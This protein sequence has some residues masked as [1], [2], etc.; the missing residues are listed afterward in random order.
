[1]GL[2][3]LDALFVDDIETHNT[4]FLCPP[5]L[6]FVTGR[7]GAGFH[8][9]GPAPALGPAALIPCTGPRLL[10]PIFIGDPSGVW[11]GR[12][13]EPREGPGMPK[14]T[15]RPRPLSGAGRGKGLGASVFRGPVCPV[16]NSNRIWLGVQAFVIRKYCSF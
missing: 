14:K 3:S 2:A 9:P 6:V 15:P 7:G 1:V 4:Q 12:G 16:T 8:S 10:P 5:N 11:V 13:P